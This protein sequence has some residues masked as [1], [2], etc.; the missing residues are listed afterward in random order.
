MGRRGAAVGLILLSTGLWLAAVVLTATYYLPDAGITYTTRLDWS[1]LA[2]LAPEVRWREV[3]AAVGSYDLAFLASLAI[4]AAAVVAYGRLGPRRA[5][6]GFASP[7]LLLFPVHAFGCLAILMDIL[8]LDTHD[9][10]FLA[11]GWPLTYTYAL[12]TVAAAATAWYWMRRATSRPPVAKSG[13]TRGGGAAEQPVAA[14]EAS[15]RMEPRR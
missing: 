7:L 6:M 14:D 2:A 15:A 4:A 1:R 5:A 10:E 12:W 3:S 11:E 8:I 9:G 13:M